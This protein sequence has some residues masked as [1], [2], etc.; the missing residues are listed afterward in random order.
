MKRR[1]VLGTIV[2]IGA[3]S[4]ATSAFQGAPG[5]GRQ[6]GPNVAQIQKITDTL[7]MITGGGGNTAAF[8]TDAG[9]LRPPY[10][11]SIPAGLAEA[12]RLGLRDL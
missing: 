1:I 11:V 8:I 9:V 5:G 12:T 6:G 10:E 2:A 7:Y 3:L 4:I